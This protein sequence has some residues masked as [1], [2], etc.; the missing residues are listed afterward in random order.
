MQKIKKICEEENL[1][2][3]E[4]L[5]KHDKSKDGISNNLIYRNY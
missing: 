3:G 2:F 1:D 4:L 5:K